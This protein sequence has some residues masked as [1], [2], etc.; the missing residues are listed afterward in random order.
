MIEFL[1]NWFQPTS[2]MSDLGSPSAQQS[3]QSAR[4][5]SRSQEVRQSMGSL[6]E[7]NRLDSRLIKK[8]SPLEHIH[9]RSIQPRSEVDVPSTFWAFSFDDGGGGLAGEPGGVEL[10]VVLKNT[11]HSSP[12][13]CSQRSLD[14]AT[15]GVVERQ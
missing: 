7:L 10:V 1:N 13:Q 5:G 3:E 4:A 12:F 11:N 9:G 15:Q 6:T 8:N 14:R 2:E